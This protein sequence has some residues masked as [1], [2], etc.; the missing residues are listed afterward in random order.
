MDQTGSTLNAGGA[1]P[2]ALPATA[3]ANA[4]I[5]GRAIAVGMLEQTEDVARS[6]SDGLCEFGDNR[7]T[8]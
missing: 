8:A 5:A 6:S 1:G 7:R 3:V 2:A 4:N